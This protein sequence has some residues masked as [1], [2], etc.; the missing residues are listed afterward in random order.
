MKRIEAEYSGSQKLASGKIR[1]ERSKVA[2]HF[3]STDRHFLSTARHFLSTARL[4]STFKLQPDSTKDF[5]IIAIPTSHSEKYD[6]KM[7][8]KN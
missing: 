8:T 3:L 1:V 2:H 6:A 7:Y 4:R 5:F